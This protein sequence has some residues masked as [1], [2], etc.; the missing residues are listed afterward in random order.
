MVYD[1]GKGIPVCKVE[2]ASIGEE[3]E[4]NVGDKVLAINGV[5]PR[6]IIDYRWLIAEENIKLE[7][8]KTNGENWI[9]EIEKDLDEPLGLHFEPP[10]IR[11]VI[12]CTNRCIFCFVDQNPPGMRETIYFKDDDYLLSFLEGNYITLNSITHEELERIVQ[13]RISPL[14]ISVHTTNLA[15]RAKMMRHKAA[16]TIVERLKYLTSGGILLHGQVVLCPDWNDQ[17][18]L[19]R[20]LADLSALGPNMQSVAVVPVGLT[21]HRHGLIPLSSVSKEVASSTLDTV[22]RFQEKMLKKR[23]TRFVY[24]SDELYLTAGYELPSEEEYED[25]PQLSN[26]VGMI[27]LFWE[28]YREWDLTE[29]KKIKIMECPLKVTMVTGEAS[30]EPIKTIKNRLNQEVEWLEVELEVIPNRFFGSQV[31]VS[32]LLTGH[33]LEQQLKD[34]ELGD[35]VIFPR[36]MLKEFSN[37]FLDNRTP[38][39]LSSSLHVPLFPAGTLQEI[40]EILKGYINSPVIRSSL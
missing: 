19:E 4:I 38:E 20:T 18:E 33:D 10:A 34:K 32:G 5:M 13:E 26:G 39:G 15:L 21:S 36:T 17:D 28:E 40:I 3:L 11:K 6:D 25:Y 31:T 16:K 22:R 37:S 30:G 12:S 1:K 24:G 27:R 2:S 8:K 14:Y 35:I 9:F 7:I 29:L 23:G